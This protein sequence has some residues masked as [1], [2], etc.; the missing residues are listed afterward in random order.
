MSGRL[1]GWRLALRL[2]ARDALRHRARSLLV[3]VMIALPV[4]AV[5]V[6]DT[7]YG[8]AETSGTEA[9]ERRLGTA[10]ALVDLGAGADRVFQLADPEDGLSYE[11]GSSTTGADVGDVREVL[12]SD[13][14]VTELRQGTIRFETELGIGDAEVVELDVDD[15]LTAGLVELTDGRWPT[16]AREVLVSSDLR[17]RGPGDELTLAG[18]TTLAVVGTAESARYTGYPRAFALPGAFDLGRRSQTS[19]LVGGGAVSWEQVRALNERGAPVTSR[20]VL[21]DPPTTEQLPVEV[22]WGTAGIDSATLTVLV[23][24]V[25]MVLLEVVLLAGPAFAV[26]ARRQARTLALVAAAGGTPAQARRVVLASGIVLGFAAATLGIGLGIPAAAAL[27][28]LFQLASDTRFGPFDVAPLHLLGVAG[29]GVLSALLAAGVPAWLASR[30]DVVAVLAGRRGDARPSRCSPLL[31]LVLLG[32]GIAAAWY[33]ASRTA[34]GAEVPI[35]VSAVTCVLGMI[36]LVPGVIVLVAR[37]SR[38]LPL[39]LRFAARDA[40]RHRTRTVPAVAAVAAT[41]AGV[42]ALGIA[43]SSDE[44]QNRETYRASLPM[45][46]ATVTDYRSDP[47]LDAYAAAVRGVAP[48]LEVQ[49]LR[50]VLEPRAEVRLG[51]ADGARLL[52]SYGGPF[53]A[54]VLVADRVPGAVL[55]IDAQQR[56]AADRVLAEGGVLA[57]TERPLDDTTSRVLLGGFGRGGVRERVSAPAVFVPVDGDYATVQGVISPEVAEELGARVADVALYLPGPVSTATAVDVAE[58]VGAVA[59]SGSFFVERGYEAPDDTV[60]VQLVLG[61]LGAVLMLGGTLTAT[62]LALSDARPDLATLSAVGAAPRTRR[63]VAAAYALVVGLVGSVLGALV[64]AVPGVAITYPL[65]RGYG[66]LEEGQHFLDVPW[67]LVLG[68][69]V[70]LPLLTAALVGLTARSRLPLAARLE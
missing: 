24:V 8:T 55:G 22:Q 9:V 69:V 3:L 39:P 58:V 68:V 44:A 61:A 60:V 11:G 67:L 27:M 17:D 29:F 20:A 23:L 42:V 57:F 48:D 18:G 53:A 38:R 13:R 34:G 35:A 65:T 56:A 30:Q 62:F 28:P 63:G 47:E 51:S 43:L 70:G 19:V 36:L 64:G 41:V 66:A 4:A 33:G 59:R 15:P 37:V 49:R 14:P 40:A 5:A 25:V 52:S 45:G 54:S 2:A 31:G 7:V 32:A 6:A 46:A 16:S 1:P 10:A 50:G 12:G 21:A 26:G